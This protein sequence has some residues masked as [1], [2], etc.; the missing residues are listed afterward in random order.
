M[1]KIILLSL[2]LV[3]LGALIVV[4]VPFTPSS[5]EVSSDTN[6]ETTT[7]QEDN[8]TLVGDD[9]DT[10]GCIASAGYTY[11]V[12]R[13]ACIR[14]WEEGTALSPVNEEETP[15]LVA[16]VVQGGNNQA[17]V[18]LPDQE[19]SIVFS[20]DYEDEDITLWTAPDGWELLLDRPG[21]WLLSQDREPLYSAPFPRKPKSK[22]TTQQAE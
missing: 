20:L 8:D 3:L 5:S 21:G 1:K 9:K 13:Q 12:L 18:F 16:Y 11:S 22:R 10:H 17:E 2:S 7:E 4:Y 6:E 15:A 19:G 14:L